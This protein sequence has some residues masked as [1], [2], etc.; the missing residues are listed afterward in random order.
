MVNASA[1][2]ASEPD[3]RDSIPRTVKD[4][5]AGS[6]AGIVQVLVGQPFDT[7]KVRLQGQSAANPI[8]KGP[9]DAFMKTYKQEGAAA[10]YKGTL[11]PLIGIGACVSI[12]FFANEYMKRFFTNRNLTSIPPSER[13]ATKPP[14]LTTV[15]L[16]ISGAASGI[17]NS[18][19]SAPVEHIRIRLQVQTTEADAIATG[20][21]FYKGPVDAIRRIY[22]ERGIAGVWKG[23]GVTVAREILA[24]SAYF[25][26]YESLVQRYM[27]REGIT[28]RTKLPMAKAMGYGAVAGFGFWIACFPVDVIKS[29]IQLDHLDPA[30]RL[31]RS[32]WHCLTHTFRAEGVPGLF[33]GFVPCMLRAAPVNSFTFAAFEIAMNLL[34]R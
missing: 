26:T 11:T 3:F 28:D 19:L 21:T 23:Q 14:P 20:R 12:Q 22:A 17:A 8:Y 30:K 27:E 18:V 15:Q 32:S 5:V 33:R 25:V 29:K 31:Y 7:I 10:F 13:S 24:Y 2:S 34:G 16:L 9:A 1:T 6:V 4:L